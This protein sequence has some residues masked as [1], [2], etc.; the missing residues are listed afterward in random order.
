[1]N[2]GRQLLDR[3]TQP[4]PLSSALAMEKRKKFKGGMVRYLVLM[5]KLLQ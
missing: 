4:L 2:M 5:K 1:M 3:L